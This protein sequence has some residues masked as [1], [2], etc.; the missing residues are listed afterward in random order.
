MDD[1]L[2]RIPPSKLVDM[3]ELRVAE[4]PGKI[5]YTFL[6]SENGCDA[7][8]SWTYAEVQRRARTIAA[9]LQENH[10]E[11]ERALLVYPACLEFN[12][13]FLGCLYA[14]VIAV[15]VYPPHFA[16]THRRVGGLEGI[17]NDATPAVALTT[18]E[19][20]GLIAATPELGFAITPD[21]MIATDDLDAAHSDRWTRPGRLDGDTVA[22]LQ[23]TSG[24]TRAPKGVVVGHN[25]LIAN[26]EP[27]PRP[28]GRCRRRSRGPVQRVRRLPATPSRASGCVAS[29][30]TCAVFSSNDCRPT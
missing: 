11:G 27:V 17:L 24:S 4:H 3:F 20:L 23:D 15:P 30:R 18:R 13:A 25:N 1:G 26:E 16:E 29:S 8:A 14:G 19:L 21:R 6:P 9:R 22:F 2:D 5:L 7:P 12:A 28:C 10:L